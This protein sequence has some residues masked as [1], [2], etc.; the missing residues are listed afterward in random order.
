M[1]PRRR[2]SR[3]TFPCGH[4]RTPGNI[5]IASGRG[6]TWTKCRKCDN[7]YMRQYM[8]QRARRMLKRRL[9]AEAAREAQEKTRASKS[10][11]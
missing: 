7:A 5:R 6:R 8:R 2:L 11:A 9:A 1:K 10:K 3:S 4:P